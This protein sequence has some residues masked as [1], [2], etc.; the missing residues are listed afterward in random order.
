M[1]NNYSDLTLNI[2]MCVTKDNVE[3]PLLE[4]YILKMIEVL[5][6]ANEA[7]VIAIKTRKRTACCDMA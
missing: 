4:V 5:I 6:T 3:L 1:I 2:N 7:W